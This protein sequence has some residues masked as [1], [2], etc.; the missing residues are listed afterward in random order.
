MTQELSEAWALFLRG[1]WGPQPKKPGRYPLR[2]QDGVGGGIGVIYFSDTGEPVAVT[3][4][5]GDWWSEPIPDMPGLRR[6]ED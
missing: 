4:W 1:H 5:G 2:C 3:P 6:E